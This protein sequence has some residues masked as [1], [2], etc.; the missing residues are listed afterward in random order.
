LLTNLGGPE[1]AR[2]N[3]NDG[4]GVDGSGVGGG[5]VGGAIVTVRATVY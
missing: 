1:F 3:V 2:E 5:G 4:G